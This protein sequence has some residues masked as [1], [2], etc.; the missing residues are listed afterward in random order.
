MTLHFRMALHGTVD[1]RHSDKEKIE[2]QLNS[3]GE[4]ILLLN[5]CQVRKRR[6]KFTRSAKSNPDPQ[7]RKVP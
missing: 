5:S 7:P 3:A 4:D 6:T 2:R 1:V